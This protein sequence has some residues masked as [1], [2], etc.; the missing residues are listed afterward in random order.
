[1]CRQVKQ[2]VFVDVV[3]TLVVEDHI[4]RDLEQIF[5]PRVVS[6]MKDEEVIRLASEPE[7]VKR[8]RLQLTEEV[9]RLREGHKILKNV[10]AGSTAEI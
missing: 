2:K 10:M 7:N 9:S 8:E 6:R 5:S 1:M 4:V 3:L